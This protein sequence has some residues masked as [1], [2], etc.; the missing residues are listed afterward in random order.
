M[1]GT[2]EAG[3]RDGASPGLWG[4]KLI[5]FRVSITLRERMQNQK[6]RI[7][8]ERVFLIMRDE[9]NF[10]WQKSQNIKSRKIAQY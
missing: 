2:Q 5:Q 9:I 6:Y 7:R 8:L 4:L 10:S 1:A 3:E